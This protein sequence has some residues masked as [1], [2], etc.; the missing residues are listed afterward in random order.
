MGGGDRSKVRDRRR[1][2]RAYSGERRVARREE[3]VGT[4][5][6]TRQSWCHLCVARLAPLV[7]AQGHTIVGAS[8]GQ[9]CEGP[10]QEER[11]RSA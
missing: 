1:D 4:L 11:S 3:L 10:R 2:G 7:Y 6:R 8:D 5:P 9:K